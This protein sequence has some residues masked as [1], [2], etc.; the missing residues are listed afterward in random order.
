[1]LM[2]PAQSAGFRNALR[3]RVGVAL[4]LATL[5]SGALAGGAVGASSVAVVD[6]AGSVAGIGSATLVS[7]PASEAP[8]AHLTLVAR[9]VATASPGR[10]VL[11]YSCPQGAGVDLTCALA[12]LQDATARGARVV[13]FSFSTQLAAVPP[14]FRARFADAVALARS[15]GTLVVAA[16]YPGGPTFPADLP[17]VM[18]VG[19][20][21]RDGE[22]LHPDDGAQMYAPGV[23]LEIT[24]GAGRPYAAFGSS[25]A[26]AWV[27]GRA[28]AILDRSPVLSLDALVAH[29]ASERPAW[30]RT[31]TELGAPPRLKLTATTR[32]SARWAKGRLVVS[33]RLPRGVGASVQYRRT[34]FG[35]RRLPCRLRLIGPVPKVAVITLARGS[36]RVRVRVPVSRPGFVSKRVTLTRLP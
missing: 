28:A 13:S 7:G 18:S 6:T 1:M 22:R 8:F 35:C 23:D 30:P 31:E 4:A 11:A 14:G 12:G 5:G 16:A 9:T 29:L 15:R 25:F 33:G 27:A 34:G 21:D 10:P 2:Y 17:M 3:R 36:A 24:D 20:I 32:L 19:A 26:T